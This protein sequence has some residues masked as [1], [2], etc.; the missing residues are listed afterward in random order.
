MGTAVDGNFCH[1]IAKDLNLG[2]LRQILIA[3]H[4]L[5]L[6][7]RNEFTGLMGE[8]VFERDPQKTSL[9]SYMDLRI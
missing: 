7:G 6:S 4:P 8:L 1:A 9:F 5:C 2:G 3:K